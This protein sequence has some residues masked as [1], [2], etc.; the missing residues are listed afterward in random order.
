MLPQEIFDPLLSSL[1]VQEPIDKQDYAWYDAIPLSF[2]SD[3]TTAFPEPSVR[4][5][6]RT[7]SNIQ[8]ERF[9]ARL[10]AELNSKRHPDNQVIVGSLLTLFAIHPDRKD[11]PTAILNRMLSKIANG[12]LSQFFIFPHPP[13]PGFEAFRIGHFLVGALD[14]QKLAYRSSRAG[15]DYFDRY[16]ERLRGLFTIERDIAQVRALDLDSLSAEFESARGSE[17]MIQLW[18]RAVES[19]FY[20]LAAAYFEEFWELLMEQQ[21]VTIALGSSYIDKGVIRAIRLANPV[22]VFMKINGTWG[23]VAAGRYGGQIIDF[24][25]I[26]TSIP[27]AVQ[28]LRDE[29]HI[30]VG[31]SMQP[32]LRSY[33]HFLSKAKRYLDQ[34]LLDESFLHHVIALELL[35]GERMA[36]AESVSRRVATLVFRPL[37][38]SIGEAKRRIEKLYDARSRYVHEGVTVEPKFLDEIKAICHEVLNA[39]MRR[40]RDVGKYE[41]GSGS[42]LKDIDYV[43]SALNAGKSVQDQEFVSCGILPT[44]TPT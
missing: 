19:Y 33:T 16:G 15:S 35:F 43:F 18:N 42:W 12:D 20:A 3:E 8:F 30:D 7:N 23:H 37:G 32:T 24:A 13:H 10:S 28:L 31:G 22:S 38:L 44:L 34:R 21:N 25:S 41:D 29:Y 1:T 40:L 26:D 17:A 27:Q 4:L 36:T 9:I 14:S 6:H 39:L 2:A 5:W 11:H